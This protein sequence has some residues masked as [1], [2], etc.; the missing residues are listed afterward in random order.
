M[1]EMSTETQPTPVAPP[2]M[3]PS[4]QGMNLPT[5]PPSKVFDKPK[6]VSSRTRKKSIPEG[7]W[8]RCKGCGE[9]ITNKELEDLLKVCPKCHYHLVA[10]AKERVQWLADTGTFEEADSN[11]HSVDAL[12][13]KGV[14]SYSDKLKAY[15]RETGL[16]D[17]VLTGFCE[18]EAHP[19]G[20]AVMDFGFLAASMGSVVGE[21]ITRIIEKSTKKKIPVVIISASGGARMYE[22]ML[23]LMQ[24]AKTSA[25][26]ARHAKAGLPFISVLTNPTMAGVMAS[27]ASLGDVILAEPH[28]MIGFAGARVI[29]ETTR[30]ELPKGFQTAEFLLERGLLDMIV[31]RKTMKSTLASL[32]EF[33]K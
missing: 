13:F 14:A 15:A 12:K 9:M 26:L 21:R 8:T 22:G 19:T 18:I 17:A 6:E 24:M 29:R 2:P 3:P 27:F 7:L 11:L 32:L 30:E 31:H 10:T 1:A 23:S 33:M 20:I 5:P 4:D 28:S 16:Q 25:A